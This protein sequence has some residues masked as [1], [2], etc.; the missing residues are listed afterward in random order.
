[1]TPF[2]GLHAIVM[3]LRG[4]YDGGGVS[5]HVWSLEYTELALMTRGQGK[6]RGKLLAFA[7]H[8]VAAMIEH[9]G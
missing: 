7:K 1:M 4:E 8:D 5:R 9:G 6:Q 3:V 2:S